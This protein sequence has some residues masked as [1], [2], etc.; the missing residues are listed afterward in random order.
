MSVH[1]DLSSERF[2]EDENVAG[3]SSIRPDMEE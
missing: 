1:G 3:N 2:R